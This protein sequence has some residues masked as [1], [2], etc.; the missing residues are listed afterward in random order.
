LGDAARPHSLALKS[1]LSTPLLSNDQLVGVLSLYSSDV[2]GFTDDHR[3][4]TEAVA[5]QIASTFERAIEFEGS[6]RRDE[7]VGLPSLTQLE[8]HISGVSR[9]VDTNA[10][11]YSLLVIDVLRFN[12]ASEDYSCATEDDALRHVARHIRAELRA[13]DILFR[14][15][16]SEFVAF[17]SGADS[18]IADAIAER[19]RV[20]VTTHPLSAN[21]SQLLV[22][23]RVT[24]L[25]SPRDGRS[26]SELLSIARHQRAADAP[27]AK[28]GVVH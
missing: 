11:R 18:L 3:R 5:R 28:N 7:L 27:T 20:N 14:N 13:A 26:P 16:G 25:C 1:C 12:Q 6:A 19:I 4:V 23:V 21:G 22:S 15:P 2:N 17:L 10:D 8:H 24:T 9:R